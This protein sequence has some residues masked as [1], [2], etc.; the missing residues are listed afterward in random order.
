MENTEQNKKNCITN[1]Y[2]NSNNNN[3]K[4]IKKMKT[5][6]NNNNNNTDNRKENTYNLLFVSA[7]YFPPGLCV[8]NFDTQQTVSHANY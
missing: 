6:N 5:D 7:I 2:E 8:C 4:I 3:N 1:N